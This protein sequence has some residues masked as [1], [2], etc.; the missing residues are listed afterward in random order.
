VKPKPPWVMANIVWTASLVVCLPTYA[1]EKTAQLKMHAPTNGWDEQSVEML[2][3]EAWNSVTT[4]ELAAKNNQEETV[5][6]VNSRA[7][8]RTITHCFPSSLYGD[9]VCHSTAD[10]ITVQNLMSNLNV[11]R[12]PVNGAR[13]QANGKTLAIYGDPR[14]HPPG[15]DRVLLTHCRR[16][17]A[18][19]ARALMAQGATAAVPEKEAH[20][21]V[22]AQDFWGRF[23]KARFHNYSLP[24]TKVLAESMPVAQTVRPSET[25]TWEGIPI[26]V[27]ATPGYTAGAV[28]Y[29]LVL[30]GKT[31][32][33][34]GDL[35]YGDGRILDLYSFQDAIPEAKIGGY[36][37][38]AARLSDL[39][40][41]LRQLL[42]EK[43]DLL[44]PARGPVI[45]RPSEA[46][47]SL[48][49]RVESLYAN[50]LSID[51]LRWY[52]GD[53]HI[54]TKA[55]RVLGPAASIDWMPMAET[56]PLPSY[57]TA[58]GN[59]R[60][61]RSA[62]GAGFL[63]DCG[64]KQILDQL[65]E[66]RRTGALA[67]LDHLFITHYHDDHTDQVPAMVD[68]FGATVLSCRE[69]CDILENPG[70]YS[71]PCL[72]RHP[73]L[74]S[75]RLSSGARWRWKEFELTAYYFPGQTLYH[76]A[77][78]VQKDGGES[79]FFIGDSFTPSGIDDY[80]L[81]NRNFLHPDTGFFQ[82]L[83]VL[84]TLPEGCWLVNQHVEPMFRFTPQQL[85]RM[86]TTLHK[87]ADLLRWLFPW[88]DPNYGLDESWA[89]LHPYSI[90]A[91]TQKPFACR[92][93]IFNHSPSERCF[94]I[95]PHLP[96]GWTL[97][98]PSPNGVWIP[99]RQ[100]GA[101]VFTVLPTADAEPGL[102]VITADVKTHQGE[103]REWIEAMVRIAP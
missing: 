7:K 43:P 19:A 90:Q 57:V 75:G 98:G 18:W 26:R 16:D 42:A 21:F 3:R 32:A 47:A 63:V 27:L 87:R 25:L 73:I 28:T 53:E 81:Q 92:A 51:A 15:A 52:F 54:L 39:M 91:E 62:D 24:S 13:L 59:T 10:S 58:I 85:E 72:T 38:Y 44:I 45:E 2:K 100:E 77:L 83:A 6:Q 40:A 68:A 66:L 17:V 99:P 60:L 14:E 50:Y 101:V 78:L 69:L 74:V 29:L 67:S 4:S 56:S 23:D 61:I 102:Y 8:A 80:C 65:Q 71:L 9:W 70:D 86:R 48:I 64:S 95:R 5:E 36:H 76:Q 97:K 1:E 55:R 82:C 12:G 103:F 22:Q 30:E 46:I 79:I 88:D 31:I 33:F 93:V 96:K 11:V 94:E 34:T 89:R 37:G 41:S 35:V 20:L 84:K 49:Q